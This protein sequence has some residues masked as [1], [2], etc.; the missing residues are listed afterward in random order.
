ME[1][2][3]PCSM[4]NGFRKVEKRL[5]DYL[6]SK[7]GSLHVRVVQVFNTVNSCHKTRNQQCVYCCATQKV[8]PRLKMFIPGNAHEYGIL[9]TGKNAKRS[10]THFTGHWVFCV[11]ALNAMQLAKPM[12][13]SAPVVTCGP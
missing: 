8:P 2:P 10:K 6:H 4:P 12:N 5:H 7:L 11:V 13:F 1:V 9:G 3:L